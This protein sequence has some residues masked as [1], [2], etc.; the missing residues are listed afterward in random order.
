[1]LLYLSCMKQNSMTLKKATFGI[2]RNR[3]ELD[4]GVS[5]LSGLGFGD[6]GASVLYP[7]DETGAQDF[8]QVQK[9]ELVSFAKIGSGLGA[10][11]FLVFIML[12]LSG[13]IPFA[14]MA[15]VPAEGRVFAVIAAM[16]LG[17]VVGAACG[18]LVGIGTPERAGRRYGQYVHAGG[19]LLS[20]H[21]DNIADQKKVEEILEKSGAQDITSV[22]EAQ[23]WRD[24]MDE[25]GNLERVSLS[26]TNDLRPGQNS[27][28]IFSLEELVEHTQSHV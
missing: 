9:N 2:Y 16:L 6:A 3:A 10:G 14:P 19:I 27:Q 7:Q 12:A 22:D 18:T 25:K 20:V 8:P 4:A 23:A 26:R 17:A 1:M 28:P 21:T 15:R 13:V 11:L 24:V 5:L